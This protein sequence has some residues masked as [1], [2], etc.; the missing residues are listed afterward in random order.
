M[1]LKDHWKGELKAKA[2]FKSAETL[3]GAGG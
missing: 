2:L 3:N 1:T